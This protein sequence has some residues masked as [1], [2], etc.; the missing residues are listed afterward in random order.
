MRMNASVSAGKHAPRHVFKETIETL[1]PHEHRVQVAAARLRVTLDDRLGRETP[2]G[3]K[4]LAKR[5]FEDLA[6]LRA[7]HKQQRT[8]PAH[9]LMCAGA[10]LFGAPLRT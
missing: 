3:V 7:R 8:A 1:S 4:A 10:V 2:D 6:T 9:I 5:P